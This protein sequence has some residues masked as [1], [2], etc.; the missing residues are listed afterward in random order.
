MVGH[1]PQVVYRINAADIIEDVN[2]AWIRF[3]IENDAPSLATDVIGRSIWDYIC[4]PEVRQIYASI[5]KRIRTEHCQVSFPFRCDSPSLYRAMR[6]TV[7]SMSK[8]QIEFCSVLETIRAQ[9]LALEILRGKSGSSS[10]CVVQMCTWCKAIAVGGEWKPIEQALEELNLLTQE[11]LPRIRHDLCDSCRTQYMQDY[12]AEDA[13]LTAK[14]QA[15]MPFV[16][17][18]FR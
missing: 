1:A 6:L 14:I 13:E 3:A 15:L 12:I 5:F 8:G 16:K 2:D 18:W 7:S 9:P 11:T 17:H 10:P 4:G